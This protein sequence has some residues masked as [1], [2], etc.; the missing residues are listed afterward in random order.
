VGIQ[1]KESAIGKRCRC[2][3]C[4]Q[5]IVIE[6]PKS[7]HEAPSHSAPQLRRTNAPASTPSIPTTHTNLWLFGGVSI[8]FL[9]LSITYWSGL[10]IGSSTPQHI[11]EELPSDSIHERDF[12]NVSEGNT[13]VADDSKKK[14][15]QTDLGRSSHAAETKPV[16]LQ[17][18]PHP[19]KLSSPKPV[20]FSG[21]VDFEMQ[22][23]APPF[24]YNAL[25]TWSGAFYYLRNFTPSAIE[26]DLLERDPS[27]GILSGT[28]RIFHYKAP[29]TRRRFKSPGSEKSSFQIFAT[30][31]ANATIDQISG[32]IELEI[33]D[34]SEEHKGKLNAT[35]TL[36]GVIAA[37]PER[38]S[39]QVFKAYGRISSRKTSNRLRRKLFGSG[40]LLERDKFDESSIVNK[41]LH[42]HDLKR[43]RPKG[44]VG[45][46][47]E[48]LPVIEAWASKFAEEYPDIETRTT[49]LKT[50][51]SYSA[52]LFGD[53]HFHE[54][55]GE[56]YDQLN[57][58]QSKAIGTV[59]TR[60]RRGDY[61][62]DVAKK[63]QSIS[64][65]Y[66]HFYISQA[67]DRTLF[68]LSQRRVIMQWCQ[69]RL[70]W[71]DSTTAYRELP[72][73]ITRFGRAAERW[74]GEL[75]PSEGDISQD[76]NVALARVG[77]DLVNAYVSEL[78]NRQL[79]PEQR[80]VTT[81]LQLDALTEWQRAS[82]VD[83]SLLPPEQLKNLGKIVQGHLNFQ[84]STLLQK[85]IDDLVSLPDEYDSIAITGKTY[86]RLLRIYAR[87]EEHSAVKVAT[88]FSTKMRSALIERHCD[89]LTTAI[90]LL[91]SKE[92]VSRFKAVLFGVPG[93]VQ[94]AS[95]ELVQNAIAA[96]IKKLDRARGESMFS[97]R[98]IALMDE[99]G[100]VIAPSPPPLPTPEE[101]RLAYLRAHAAEFGRMISPDTFEYD[102][103]SPLL[104]AIGNSTPAST[105]KSRILEVRLLSPKDSKPTKDDLYV[106]K[107]KLREQIKQS[108]AHDKNGEM[109]KLSSIFTPDAAGRTWSE[110]IEESFI[111]TRSGWKSPSVQRR[112]AS[113]DAVI[114]GKFMGLGKNRTSK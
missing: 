63:F 15:A 8:V 28:A 50:L 103:Y 74:L 46:H 6:D 31:T 105:V 19:P 79:V 80:D 70:D 108:F 27:S 90:S 44:G 40:F 77:P 71:L 55:F 53:K 109:A 18:L 21:V 82:P 98:E 106:L 56:F 3:K 49:T 65:F 16:S 110:T 4:Q 87:L 66:Y 9:A 29:E 112:I 86:F 62:S 23:R 43:S 99:S 101:I 96:R 7:S 73:H 14:S 54:H 48:L 2:P 95:M 93:S 12:A 88:D 97:A 68:F 114:G 5:E 1:A 67:R 107:F 20:K 22:E 91:P 10:F 92:A 35:F 39:G 94:G 52:N 61:G 42:R 17:P 69:E 36:K 41:A 72:A 45:D 75:F 13:L 37:L 47:L 58:N 84:L 38:I 81:K 59:L 34:L 102:V 30:G 76:I 60:A 78:V 89:E 26:V 33:F 64:P 25:G 104:V 11:S 32:E 111:L 83:V 57:E 85:E 24:E 113:N 51:L 100:D